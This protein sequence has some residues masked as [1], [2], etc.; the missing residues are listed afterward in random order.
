MTE[1]LL[2]TRKNPDPLWPFWQRLKRRCPDTV[3]PR[4][5]L[6]VTAFP[7]CSDRC[8][9]GHLLASASSN[10]NNP[11]NYRLRLAKGTSTI[12]LIQEK[13]QNI[14]RPETQ[15]LQTTQT[16]IKILQTLTAYST[17]M[18]L[19]RFMGFA[20]PNGEST[21]STPVHGSTARIDFADAPPTPLHQ[22]FSENMI[23]QYIA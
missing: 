3:S 9:Y 16:R 20:H 5:R 17:G 21:L 2:N 11:K 1:T 6:W 10:D 15:Y 12:V 23:H 19:G 14:C 7:G 18:L 4:S 22:E 8:Y 13:Q